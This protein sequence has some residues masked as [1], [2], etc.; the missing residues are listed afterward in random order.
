MNHTQLLQQT[1][2]ESICSFYVSVFNMRYCAELTIYDQLTFIYIRSFKIWFLVIVSV[3]VLQLFCMFCCIYQ[4][5]ASSFC[6]TALFLFMFN[7]ECVTSNL[8]IK[9]GACGSQLIFAERFHLN[10]LSL[11]NYKLI[12]ITKTTMA[13]LLNFFI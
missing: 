1:P 6:R 5:F 13:N 2:K 11:N 10:F 7:T 4:P 8:I 3:N 12:S 9:I